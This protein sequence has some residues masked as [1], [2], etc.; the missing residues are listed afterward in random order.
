MNLY[1]MLSSNVASYTRVC[2]SSI[3]QCIIFFAIKN[4]R[5]RNSYIDM[6]ICRNVEFRSTRLD[7]VE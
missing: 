1:S 7:H 3:D 2:C 4:D 5:N 6:F